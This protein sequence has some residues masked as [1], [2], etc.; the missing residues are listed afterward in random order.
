MAGL[1]N[2]F[3]KKKEQEVA[4]G[5]NASKV[6]VPPLAGSRQES[7]GGKKVEEKKEKNK[8]IKKEGNKKEVSKVDKGEKMI[9]PKGALSEDLE[10]VIIKP[11]IT[12]KSAFLA[13]DNQYVFIVNRGAGRIQVRNAIKAMYGIAPTNV[14]IQNYYGKRVRFGRIRGKQSNWKKAIVTLPKGSKI[15]VYEGV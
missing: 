12:E 7:A 9:K 2:R 5:G 3:K 1:L 14:N 10:R 11:Y 15:D 4:R 6:I 13:H 8:K